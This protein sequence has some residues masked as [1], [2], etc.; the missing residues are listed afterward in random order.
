MK[1]IAKA[2][3]TNADYYSATSTNLGAIFDRV[4]VDIG[5]AIQ[6]EI[7]IKRDEKGENP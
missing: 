6:R 3:G 5:L 4:K 7:G 2:G 1:R